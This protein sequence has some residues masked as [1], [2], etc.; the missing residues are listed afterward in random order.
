MKKK[1]EFRFPFIVHKARLP[2]Q[3]PHGQPSVAGFR[4]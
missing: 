1:T 4:V 3:L 2:G